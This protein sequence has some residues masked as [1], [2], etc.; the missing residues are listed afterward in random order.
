MDLL[1]QGLTYINKMLFIV[2]FLLSLE[3]RKSIWKGFNNF[4]KFS[5]F[6]ERLFTVIIAALM[7]CLSPYASIKDRAS[8]AS[9]FLVKIIICD[10]FSSS[11][12]SCLLILIVQ[13]IEL[14]RKAEWPTVVIHSQKIKTKTL[15]RET[16]QRT[17]YL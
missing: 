5:Q 15:W 6:K 10:L 3:S 13:I 1:Y 7:Y 11:S 9:N 16:I 4:A 8:F 14:D 2:L 12:L 17:L